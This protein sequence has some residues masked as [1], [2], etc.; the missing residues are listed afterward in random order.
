MKKILVFT[1]KPRTGKSLLSRMLFKWGETVLFDGRGEFPHHYLRYEIDPGIKYIILDDLHGITKMEFLK[2]FLNNKSIKVERKGEKAISMPTP[3]LIIT[4]S[5]PSTTKYLKEY[6]EQIEVIDF[7]TLTFREVVG[8]IE[9][10]NI[11][12]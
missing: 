5:D 9:R 1:G 12:I 10:Y 3:L 8:I 6:S 11:E 7:D 4:T 2:I